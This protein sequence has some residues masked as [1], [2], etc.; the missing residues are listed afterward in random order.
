[1][2]LSRLHSILDAIGPL[3]IAVSGGVD[4]MTLAVVAHHRLPGQV[5]LFHAVS[6]AVPPDATRRVRG[7]AER[8]GW[9]LAVIGAGELDD[10]N[11]VANPV[12][13]C[14]Y[15]KTNLYGSIAGL[16]E[17]P[18]ASGAN[19]DDLGDYRP[20]LK[21]AE[22]HRVHHPYIEAGI[23]KAG[24][25]AIAASL[26]LDDLAE[27]PSSPCL[28]SRIES[29]IAVRADLLGLIDQ[30][31]SLARGQVGRTE[32]LRVRLRRDGVVLELDAETLGRLPALAQSGL[33]K[34][35]ATLFLAAGQAYSVRVEPYRRGSAFLKDAAG[36]A[37]A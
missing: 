20:G 28:S 35:I 2:P 34:E 27:L 11:Y 31:E 18:I 16:T 26:G 9:D 4:S 29:G 23:G 10:P 6:A 22:Q 1:M 3:A 7:H 33:A 8:E 12:D 37:P 14:F 30:A 17:L 25:R 15:C 32:A 5:R 24:I 36:R 19:V 21:A 13:R